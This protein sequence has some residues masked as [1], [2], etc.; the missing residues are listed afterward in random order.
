M[1]LAKLLV[2]VSASNRA[3]ASAARCEEER[4]GNIGGISG[5]SPEWRGT[6]DTQYRHI[7]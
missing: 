2:E 6:G 1:V 5:H 4:D 7:S 3:E